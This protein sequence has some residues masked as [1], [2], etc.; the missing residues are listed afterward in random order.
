MTWRYCRR[1]LL[2]RPE[3]RAWDYVRSGRCM[4]L[5]DDPIVGNTTRLRGHL[6]PPSELIRLIPTDQ[7]IDRF[8]PRSLND[9]SILLM[10]NEVGQIESRVAFWSCHNMCCHQ[11]EGSE[12]A[13]A[14]AGVL[15]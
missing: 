2:N 7:I 10:I 3:R 9:A 1:E 11:R 6:C 13:S 12:R 5:P 14:L 4:R 15:R 8:L